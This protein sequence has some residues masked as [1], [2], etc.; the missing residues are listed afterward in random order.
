MK[1]SIL[2]TLFLLMTVRLFAP[3][4]RSLVIFEVKP[5]NPYESIIKA[6]NQVESANGKYL[7]N[8]KENAVGHF[9]IRPIRLND[10]N[11]RTEQ[12]I[13]LSEC[14]DYATG[15]RIFLYYASQIDYR[16]IKAICISWNG[17]SIYNKYYKN[18]RAEMQKSE[19]N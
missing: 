14:N 6:V 11:L 15:R 16:D 13:K 5:V 9:G 2:I 17:K 8:A 19:N 12:N 10:Y 1:K 18:I 7:F 3:E 4:Y